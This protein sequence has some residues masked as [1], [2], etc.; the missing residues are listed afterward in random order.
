MSW[1]FWVSV[2]FCVYTYAIFPL[3]L[4]VFARRKALPDRVALDDYPS[5]SIVIA[6]HNEQANLET[7]LNSLQALD[8]PAGKLQLIFVSDGSTDATLAMLNS[9]KSSFEQMDVLSYSPAAGK[10]TALNKGVELS[11]IHI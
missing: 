9:A 8:Y 4:H 11:L 2:I 6:A 10:P 7:K 5:V 1:L 3:L